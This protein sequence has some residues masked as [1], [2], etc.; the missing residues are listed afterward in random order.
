MTAKEYL[1]QIY[2]CNRRMKRIQETREQLRID[3]YSIGSPMGN[4]SSDRVQT[5]TSGDKFG[6]MI[7]RVDKLERDLVKEHGRMLALK[8]K[9]I[10]QIE[11]MDNEQQRSVLYHRYVLCWK[12]SA[13]A[14]DMMLDERW[15][16]RIH[17]Q[18][19]KA[20]EKQF[21]LTSERQ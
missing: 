10:R 21:K 1:Q 6:R 20:F 9:I 15:I 2:V 12:W 5:S 4:M 11:A 14:E 19:L 3:M 17:G 16:Y 8:D 13:I 7:A 18:A